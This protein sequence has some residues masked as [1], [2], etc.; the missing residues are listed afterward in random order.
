MKENLHI[1]TTYSD[2]ELTVAQIV[3]ELKRLGVKKFS[4]TDHDCVDGSVEAKKLADKNGMEYV[5]GIEL[6]CCFSD[7]EIGLDETWSVHILGYNIN[8]DKMRAQ[9]Q[10]IN[11]EKTHELKELCELLVSDGYKIN[12]GRAMVGGKIP[13]R[14]TI[15]RELIA[16]GYAKD[17]DEAY[18]KILNTERYRPFANIKPSIKKGIEIIHACDGL[19]VWAHP[20]MVTRGG[21]KE[22]TREQVAKLV[23]QMQKYGLDGMEVFYQ[24]FNDKQIA[25]L[26]EIADKNPRL[27]KTVGT[28][29]HGGNNS[30]VYD[31]AEIKDFPVAKNL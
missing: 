30:L 11:D 4:I 12:I 24:K 18:S 21:K 23:I 16:C 6:S 27:V 13:A 15:S 9:L 8:V 2:G 7:H 28:D 10:S 5:T 22:I 1:H 29:F 3:A 20:F 26:N 14:K 19:A 31:K 17:P 25:F